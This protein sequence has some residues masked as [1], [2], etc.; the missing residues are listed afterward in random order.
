MLL[1]VSL[2]YGMIAGLVLFMLTKHSNEQLIRMM[3]VSV[4]WPITLLTLFINKIR[5]RW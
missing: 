2:L 3:I 1:F 4:F 5:R